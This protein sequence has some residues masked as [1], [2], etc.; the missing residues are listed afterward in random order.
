MVNWTGLKNRVCKKNIY[1]LT[2][3]GAAALYIL[4]SAAA[5][6]HPSRAM[7]ENENRELQ[8]SRNSVLSAW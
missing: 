5:V 2:A 6:L 4:I 8:D 3:I 7:S 1:E